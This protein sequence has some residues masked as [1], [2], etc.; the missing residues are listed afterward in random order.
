M[1]SSGCSSF[2]EYA[3]QIKYSPKAYAAT[4]CV[5]QALLNKYQEKG[6]FLSGVTGM[7]SL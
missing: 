4:V 2:I 1:L 5:N 6:E 7:N 3:S